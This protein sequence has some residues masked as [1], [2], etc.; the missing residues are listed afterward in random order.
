M[1]GRGADRPVRHATSVEATFAYEWFA[2]LIEP[3][4]ERFVL[5]HP[6]KLCVVAESAKK[7]ENLNA[8]TLVE[9]TDVPA[10]VDVLAFLLHGPFPPK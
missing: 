3:L 4:A 6:R 8:R 1:R 10:N 7:T 2:R 9:S 5:A